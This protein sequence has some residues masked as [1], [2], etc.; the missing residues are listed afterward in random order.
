[1]RL[2]LVC[3]KSPA[4]ENHVNL[5]TQSGEVRIFLGECPDEKP[6]SEI[7]NHSYAAY[8]QVSG[9]VD[10]FQ[11]YKD[12]GIEVTSEL[13]TKPWGMREFAIR[14]PDGHRFMFGQETG[15]G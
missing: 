11:D 13:E 2:L 10:L 5:G 15:S 6:A 14:T 9:I 7:G 4:F 3:W 12:K 1:M 8:F